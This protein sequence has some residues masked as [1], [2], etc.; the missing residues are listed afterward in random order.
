VSHIAAGL[1]HAPESKFPSDLIAMTTHGRSGL[2][3]LVFGSV[4][5]AVLRQADI[6]VFM[7][8]LT[9]RQVPAA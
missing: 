6:P 3:R 8:R 1:L 2:G 7:M 9:E 4:A 5:E